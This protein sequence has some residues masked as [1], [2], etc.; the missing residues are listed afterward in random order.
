M[1][2]KILSAFLFVATIACAQTAEFFKPYASTDLRLPSVPLVVNDPYFSI[3]S[4]YDKLTDGTTRHWT[5]DEKPILGLLRVDGTAYR[6]MGDQQ[7][8]ILSSIAPM[9]DEER[10]EGK[11]SYQKPADGWQKENFNDTNWST[12]K[13]AWGTEGENISNRRF[14][15]QGSDIYIRR[16]VELTAQQLQEDL[17]VKYSHDDVFELYINGTKVADTGETWVNG[18]VLH[19][20]SDLKNLLH[21]GKNIISAHCH[22]TTGGA[23]VDFGLFK[24]IK[25]KGANIQVAE[26]KSVDV[27]ATNTYYTFACGP[28]EL[29]VVFTAPMLIDDYDLISM[30]VNYISYQ[31]RATDGRKHD[32]QMYISANPLQAVNKDTQPTIT[33]MGNEKGVQYVRTGTIEQPILAKSGDGICIDWGYFYIPAIN[34]RV[35]MGDAS[36]IQNNFV[37]T[38]RT[39]RQGQRGSE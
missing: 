3:W 11:V 8:Y 23:Y 1:R 38:G 20:E 27:L 21:A 19:L 36:E 26:Q 4:P 18:V 17:Y 31:V 34:G 39:F 30:P 9:S 7:N 25:P 16:E 22:N 33:T 13:A 10:W 24:N 35:M 28:V 15:R 5:N 6:F 14:G 32:V 2:K 12:E 29:D 37:E